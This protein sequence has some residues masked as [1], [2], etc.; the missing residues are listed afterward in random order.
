MLVPG[1][2]VA[3]RDGDYASFVWHPG[4]PLLD[5]WLALYREAA[6]ANG[7]E[8]DAG[9]RLFGWAVAAGFTEVRPS[10][11]AWNFASDEDRAWWGGLWAERVT[12][13][14]LATQLLESGMATVGELEAIAAAFRHWS[15]QTDACFL[16]PHGEVIAV[17]P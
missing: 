16:V 11:S 3:A 4:D 10:A 14:A 8:P 9:R 17:A 1:G 15:Q 5:R 2:I 6:R 7:A 12:K 13:S